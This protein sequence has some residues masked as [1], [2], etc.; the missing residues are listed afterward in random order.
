VV[1]IQSIFRLEMH[2]NDIFLFFEINTSKRFENI[3]KISK[4][5]LKFK[6]TRFHMKIS[7][8]SINI[9]NIISG[10]T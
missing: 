10:L 4:K 6:G 1:A 7:H 5:N 2:Q 3:K 8:A 9:R